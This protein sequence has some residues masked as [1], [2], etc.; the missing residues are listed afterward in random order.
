MKDNRCTDCPFYSSKY[1]GPEGRLD[2]KIAIIGEAPGENEERL[3]RPFVGKAGEVLGEYLS[4]VGIKREHC[5]ITNVLKCRPPNNK[6]NTPEARKAIVKCAPATLRELESLVSPSVIVPV[7]NTALNLL[8][9]NENIGRVRGSVSMSRFGKVIPTWHPAFYFRAPEE[10][11]TGSYDWRKIR[12]HSLMRTLIT[13]SENFNLFPTVEDIEQFRLEVE[14]GTVGGR[15]VKLAIDIETYE[16]DSPLL[17]PIKL[18]ALARS[19]SDVL[20][21]PF[22][23]E[24]GNLYWKNKDEE[25]RVIMAIGDILANPQVIKIVFNALFDMLVMMNHGWGV[26]GPI[27][28][29]MLAHYLIYHPVPHTLEYVASIY[30][31][32]EAW[33]LNKGAGNDTEYR[34]YNARDAAMLFMIEDGIREDMK[35][36][37]V[38]WAYRNLCGAILPAC[39]MMLNGIRIDQ[40]Q[41]KTVTALLEDDSTRLTEK[42]WELSGRPDLNPRSAK[43]LRDVLFGQ[44]KLRSQ[45]KTKKSKELATSEDVLNRLSLRYP[46]NRFVDTMLEFRKVDKLRGTYSN[47]H[48]LEDGRVHSQ[49]MLHGSRTGRFSYRNPNIGNLPHHRGDPQGYI[50]R[51]Y[52]ADPGSVII[53]ADYSQVELY[54]FALIAHDEPWLKAFQRKEDIHRLNGI[55][56]TGG[57]KEEYRTFYKNFIYGFIYGSEGGEIEKVAPKELIQHISVR[58]MIQNLYTAHPSV[59]LYRKDIEESVMSKHKVVNS[60]GRVRWFPGR[61]SR[62]DVRSGFNH[63]IQSDVAEIM[64]EKI[65]SIDEEL[66]WP[67]DKLL[68]QLHDAFYVETPERRAEFVANKMKDIMQRPVYAPTG[69]VIPDLRVDI[70]VGVNMWDMEGFTGWLS[71]KRA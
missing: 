56:L 21:V 20:V 54:I 43:Q 16:L 13:P 40:E 59:Y 50:R 49:A 31:D 61:P 11:V 23:N 57:Y 44:M 10:K 3:G 39:R 68:L 19:S 14:Q 64:H 27:E 5:Y 1:V 15:Q 41:L 53:E 8:G 66:S 46:D 51:M 24:S 58:Q 70:K 32:Y 55:A 34:T 17:T 12:R 9:I 60:F 48:V 18:I 28:D 47:P 22:I 2:A 71:Q 42:L 35:S 33:K 62:G 30:A 25:L 4:S 65:K 67:E 45:V 52:I 63:P 26:I 36:N 38:E 6:I 37:R 7:G 69:L 29:F